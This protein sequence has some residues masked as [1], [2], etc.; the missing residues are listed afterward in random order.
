MNFPVATASDRLL[1]AGLDSA[2]IA[3][4]AAAEPNGT[5]DYDGDCRRYSQFWAQSAALVRRLRRCQ[6]RPIGRFRLA[7]DIHVARAV[8]RNG[9]RLVR[10]RAA[11]IRGEQQR[12]PGR[13]EA[14][15]KRVA[16]K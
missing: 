2:A 5:A 11:K 3:E 16:L 1:D 6:R 8:D 7:G 15:H 13:V 12:G 9:L 10:R 14:R 4:W